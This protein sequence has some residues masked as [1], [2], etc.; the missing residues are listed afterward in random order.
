MKDRKG[1]IRCFGKEEG[2]GKAKRIEKEGWKVKKKV[3]R[4]QRLKGQSKEMDIF[5]KINEKT[6]SA[7]SGGP[8]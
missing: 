1:L 7:L 3:Y 6:W 5:Q 4:L 2:G 8:M